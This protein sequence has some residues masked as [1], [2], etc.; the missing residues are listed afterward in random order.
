MHRL[1]F[2]KVVTCEGEDVVG[3]KVIEPTD[4]DFL[5]LQLK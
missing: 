3:V 5:G 1:G 2:C 4:V